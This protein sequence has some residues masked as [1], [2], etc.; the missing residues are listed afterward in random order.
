[1]KRFTPR[2]IEV[3]N[4]LW[5]RGASTVTEV[6][7]VLDD[8]SAYTTILSALRTLEAKGGVTRELVGRAHRYTAFVPREAATERAVARLV[9]QFFGSREVLLTHLVSKEHMSPELL[10]TLRDILNHRVKEEET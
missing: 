3:L 8:G 5:D 10:R 9:S 2:E 6:R 1:M 7:E 4:V